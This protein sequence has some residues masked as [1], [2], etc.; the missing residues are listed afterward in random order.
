VAAKLGGLQRFDDNWK[1]ALLSVPFVTNVAE[2]YTI[3]SP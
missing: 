3:T 1:D 2:F